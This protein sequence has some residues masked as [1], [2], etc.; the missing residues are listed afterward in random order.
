MRERPAAEGN[1]AAIFYLAFSGIPWYSVKKGAQQ[2]ILAPGAA[3]SAALFLCAECG[4]LRSILISR[5]TQF[6]VK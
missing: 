3:A 2:R 5:E 6:P 4:S 1:P